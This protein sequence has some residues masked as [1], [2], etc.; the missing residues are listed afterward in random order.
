MDPIKVQHNLQS[1]A[2]PIHIKGEELAKNGSKK[3]G[4]YQNLELQ[5]LIIS[6]GRKFLQQKAS[7]ITFVSFSMRICY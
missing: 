4:N 1:T 2:W 5:S 7:L 3:V 6:C